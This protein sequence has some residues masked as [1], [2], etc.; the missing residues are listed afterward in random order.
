MVPGGAYGLCPL[1]GGGPYGFGGAYG[2]GG[3]APGGAG[4]D[5]TGVPQGCGGGGAPYAGPAGCPAGGAEG[6][7][8]G[9]SGGG[10]DGGRPGGPDPAS[11]GG[12]GNCPP[13]GAQK[14]GRSRSA[15]PQWGHCTRP[16][17]AG[18]G[19]ASSKVAISPR[20]AA[21]ARTIGTARHA[22]VPSP[23]R[24]SRSSTGIIPRCA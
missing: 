23:S 5:G 9:G 1:P 18:S 2:P 7:P 13:E 22:P 21:A 3:A 8:G 10:G 24:S 6:G 19:V 17:Y 14:R 16:A 4:G 20:T 11:C 15:C 12:C